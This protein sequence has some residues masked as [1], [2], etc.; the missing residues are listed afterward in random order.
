MLAKV[1]MIF[2]SVED[3]RYF[4]NTFYFSELLA[5]VGTA[6]ICFIFFLKKTHFFSHNFFVVVAHI[7]LKAF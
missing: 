4:V 7:N 5:S 3:R 2:A 1:E 6:A